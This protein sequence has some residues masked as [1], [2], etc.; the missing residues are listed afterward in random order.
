MPRKDKEESQIVK[1]K[2]ALK[3]FNKIKE[4]F[5]AE[6]P[7]YWSY[8][9]LAKTRP[10]WKEI[11]TKFKFLQDEKY[12]KDVKYRKIAPSNKRFDAGGIG[13]RLRKRR[14]KKAQLY[15][16]QLYIDSLVKESMEQG[17]QYPEIAFALETNKGTIYNRYKK[18]D[19][20]IKRRGKND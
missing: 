5:D 13:V 16:A 10:R 20:F 18:E 14:H 11:E 7:D 6:E 4:Q 9:A 1:L 19:W 2:K 15:E 8:M 12:S 17:M 3:A